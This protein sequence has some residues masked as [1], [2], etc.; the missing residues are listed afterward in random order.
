MFTSTW[1]GIA[2]PLLFVPSIFL[3]IT[4]LSS[5][6]SLNPYFA[7]IFLSIKI[8]VVLLSRSTFTVML[9]CISTFSTSIFNYTSLSILNVLLISLCLSSPFTVLFRTPVYA[10]LL[11]NPTMAVSLLSHI[12]GTESSLYPSLTSLL[13]Y[14]FVH[15]EYTLL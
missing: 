5:F 8:S 3:T 6:Y 11:S 13:L 9:L 12:L 14:F 4:G 10:P 15:I 2:P 7:A 1:Y